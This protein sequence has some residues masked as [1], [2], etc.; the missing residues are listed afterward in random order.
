MKKVLVTGAAGFIGYHLSKSLLNKGYE[1]VGIDNMNSYYNVKLKEARIADIIENSNFHFYKMD[2]CDMESMNVLFDE[3]QFDIIVNLAAQAGVRYSIDNPK[4]Y[5]DSNLCGFFNILELCR[6]HKIEHLVF[7]SSSSVYGNQMKTPF[8]VADRTDEPVSLYA[9]TKKC[10]ELLGH[11]YSY[12]YKIP[13]TGLRFFTVY[14]PF[15][16]PD[17][18]YFSFTEK[19][20]K[21]ETIKL[22]NNGEMIRDFTYVDDVVS[23]IEKIMNEKPEGV[24]PFKVY[25]IGNCHPEPL[26]KLV[27]CIQNELEKPAKIEYLPMQKGDVY[28]TFA[29]CTD[30]EEK[31]GYHPTTSLEEGIHKFI[32]WYKTYN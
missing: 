12:L 24:T 25:N 29:D 22:F 5:L 26:Q 8:S 31:F 17:M 23:G 14:G 18:A 20:E 28:Q 21:G 32:S 6:H 1:I 7:A 27:D 13:M 16:R 2:I 19:I 9:A 4:A 10:N 15:G 3:N 11:S 30:I